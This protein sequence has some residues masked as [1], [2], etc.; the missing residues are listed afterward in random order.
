MTANAFGLHINSVSKV[1]N[2]ACQAMTY[3]LGPKYQHLPRDEDQKGTKVA[4]I[5]AKYGMLQAFGFIDGTHIRMKR[6][7]MN[8][9][10][11]FSY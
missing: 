8:S 10:D 9:H 3:K 1:I 5:E 7:T 2:E 6:P 11:Y 4:E